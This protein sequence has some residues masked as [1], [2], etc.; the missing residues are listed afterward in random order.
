MDQQDRMRKAADA[1]LK[2]IEEVTG[3]TLLF[4]NEEGDREARESNAHLRIE[5]VNAILGNP[6]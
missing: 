6:L 4:P 1:V 3:Q 2:A 5:I